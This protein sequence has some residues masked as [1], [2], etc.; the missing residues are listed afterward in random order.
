MAGLHHPGVAMVY[1]IGRTAEGSP[2]IAM[3]LASGGTLDAL[4]DQPVAW[5]QLK[6]LLL[7]LLDALAHAHARGVLHRDLKPANLLLCTSAD[8][9]PGLKVSDF[10]LAMPTSEHLFGFRGPVKNAPAAPLDTH[11]FTP[12]QLFALSTCCE[13]SSPRLQHHNE[14][15]YY[16]PRLV[17]DI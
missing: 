13:H 7:S 14:Q 12:L 8:L 16:H 10:G 3:E 6:E 5:S 17:P 1:D 15:I 4:V 11:E 9:R 2:W